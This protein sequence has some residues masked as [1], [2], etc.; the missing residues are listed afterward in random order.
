MNAPGIIY[1]YYQL[2]LLFQNLIGS[3]V[4]NELWY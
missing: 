3:A 4:K 2:F 1:D